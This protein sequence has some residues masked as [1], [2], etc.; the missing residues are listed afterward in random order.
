MPD[1]CLVWGDKGAKIN[2]LTGLSWL[3]LLRPFD[4][5]GVANDN[6]CICVG[7]SNTTTDDED[8]KNE[9]WCSKRSSFACTVMFSL[10]Y[11]GLSSGLL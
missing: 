9:I 6:C 7:G 4:N 3:R 11:L 8:D 5:K 2:N 10:L 1:R